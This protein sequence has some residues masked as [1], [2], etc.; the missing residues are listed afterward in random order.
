MLKR[1][2][3]NV[4]FSCGGLLILINNT[5]E[6]IYNHLSR[7]L[8]P[9]QTAKGSFKQPVSEVKKFKWSFKKHYFRTQ[10]TL[11]VSERHIKPFC[12]PCVTSGLID[13]YKRPQRLRLI[14]KGYAFPKLPWW[15]PQIICTNLEKIKRWRHLIKVWARVSL[16]NLLSL[17]MKMRWNKTIISKDTRRWRMDNMIKLKSIK[18]R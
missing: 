17:W 2:I 13:Y 8:L 12:I 15:L 6:E 5:E 16:P 9:F 11:A 14:W 4:N 7:N 3:P 1:V 10:Y 18:L